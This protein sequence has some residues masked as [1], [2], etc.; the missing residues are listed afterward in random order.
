MKTQR[1][2][3]SDFE[4]WLQRSL[5]EDVERSI[6]QLPCPDRFE[7]IIANL[8]MKRGKKRLKAMGKKFLLTCFIVA[9]MT[10]GFCL[11]YPDKV[12]EAGRRLLASM[13]HLFAGDISII[14]SDSVYPFY[15]V[16]QK[17]I[18]EDIIR[19]K[20]GAPMDIKLPMYVPPGF[21]ATDVSSIDAAGLF[22][23]TLIFDNGKHKF[24]ITQMKTPNTA[25]VLL[26]D[27]E[28][29]RIR[30]VTV[31]GN[32]G[33]LVQHRDGICNVN[34]I[35]ENTVHFILRGHIPEDEALKIVRSLN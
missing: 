5:K 4:I 31:S 14:T 17:D 32:K 19:T 22:S 24:V 28:K 13:T 6:G 9:L 12:G 25:A 20:A 10:S 27:E 7:M 33:L 35:D 1:R 3:P 30:E 26:G 2:Y 34:F 11:L 16:S 23:V 8:E 21:K 18:V 29:E 15:A